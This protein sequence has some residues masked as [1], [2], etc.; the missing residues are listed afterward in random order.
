MFLSTACG[1]EWSIQSIE[2]C[3]YLTSFDEMLSL[4]ASSVSDTDVK[5]GEEEQSEPLERLV[6]LIE[7]EA[8]WTTFAKLP[9][10]IK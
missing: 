1:V 9:W 3:R 4:S 8:L 7:R 6:E 10:K 5:Q 2:G